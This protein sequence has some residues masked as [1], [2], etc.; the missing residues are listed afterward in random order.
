[1][2]A[3]TSD[4]NY[5]NRVIRTVR[6]FLRLQD[7]PGNTARKV[8]K[9]VVKLSHARKWCNCAQMRAELDNWFSVNIGSAVMW[10]I[11]G[12]EVMVKGNLPFAHVRPLLRTVIF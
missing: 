8:T 5:D 10:R 4:F 3:W 1:M 9:M 2:N 11:G 6:A 12:D 7:K